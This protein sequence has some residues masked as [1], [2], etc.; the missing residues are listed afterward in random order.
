MDP[1]RLP[2]RVPAGVVGSPIRVHRHRLPSS[3]KRRVVASTQMNELVHESEEKKP[4]HLAFA[5]ALAW[6]V[7]SATMSRPSLFAK[8]ESERTSGYDAARLVMTR[9]CRST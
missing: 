8:S 4:G 3:A 1:C 6:T 9:P 2:H 5:E 7:W